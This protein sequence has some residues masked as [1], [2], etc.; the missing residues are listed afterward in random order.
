M[1]SNVKKAGIT[2]TNVT[3][4]GATNGAAVSLDSY[5][6][7]PI[8]VLTVSSRTDGSYTLKLQHSAD[9]VNWTDYGSGASALTAD[10]TRV[11]GIDSQATPL[12]TYIRP[13]VTAGAVT[14]GATVKV[15]LY[16][17]KAK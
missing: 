13:V 14:T 17:Q 1:A 10:G 5:E 11:L 15:D 16:V 12:L 7:N 4:N 6:T 8:A 2:S 3:A 9:G